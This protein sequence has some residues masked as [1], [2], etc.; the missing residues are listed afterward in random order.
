MTVRIDVFVPFAEADTVTWVTLLTGPV[1]AVNVADEAPARTV[2]LPGTV[3]EGPLLD[4]VTT[5]PPK[6]AG[7]FKMT[8]PVD[9]I[10]PNTVAGLRETDCIPSVKAFT[11]SVVVFV[12]PP[13]AE[14]VTGV[15]TPT[16]VVLI[17]NVAV[18]DPAGTVTLAG[19]VAAALLLDN[20]MGQ[21]PAGAGAFNVTVPVAAYPPLIVD[22]FTDTDSNEVV[23]ICRLADWIPFPLAVI[24]TPPLPPTGKVVIVKFAELDPC[25]TVTVAGTEAISGWLLDNSM[26]SPPFGAAI[27]KFTVP[28][29][30]VPPAT[31]V[32]LIVT[33]DI[34]ASGTAV[35]TT[36][37]Q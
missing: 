20:A 2:T 5:V 37:A 12:V 28:V 22:G 15:L 11:V 10:P 8:V 23:V 9:E 19:T 30:V 17:P 31:E 4:R 26:V 27:L 33:E 32:G 6:G 7:P 25:G 21:P 1:V 16:A 3:T 18:V 29:L 24:C 13:V 34:T 35:N 36:S 14:I